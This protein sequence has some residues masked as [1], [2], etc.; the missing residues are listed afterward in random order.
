MKQLIKITSW[1]VQ[2]LTDGKPRLLA[3]TAASLRIDIIIMMETRRAETHGEKATQAYSF[4]CTEHDGT[5]NHGVGFMVHKDIKVLDFKKCRV[6]NSDSRAAQLIIE[7]RKGK[8]SLYALYAPHIGHHP[9]ILGRCTRP[10]LHQQVHCRHRRKWTRP[11]KRL[12]IPSHTTKPTSTHTTNEPLRTIPPCI[13]E[14]TIAQARKHD[15]SCRNMG[16]Q[17]HI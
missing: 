14:Q 3:L 15:A 11:P 9:Q 2:S 8:R 12:G 13:H 5:S 17:I 10:T 4:W 7:T 16:I 1:N 6:G